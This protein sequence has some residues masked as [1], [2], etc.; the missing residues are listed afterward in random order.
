M[1][2]QNSRQEASKDMEKNQTLRELEE[3]ACFRLGK[4][5]IIFQQHVYNVL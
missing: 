4:A 5:R 2:G 3:A 1:K